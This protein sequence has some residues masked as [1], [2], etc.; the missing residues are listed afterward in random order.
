[1]REMV[2]RI[3]PVVKTLG[4][5]A[6]MALVMISVVIVVRG[7]TSSSEYTAM[8]T[9]QESGKANADEIVEIDRGEPD[10]TY[11]V[12]KTYSTVKKFVEDLKEVGYDCPI[13]HQ[14]NIVTNAASSGYCSANDV[15]SVYASADRRD[16]QV[17][18]M[19]ALSEG[20]DVGGHLVIGGN[21]MLNTSDS[22]YWSEVT[23][24]IEVVW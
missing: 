7:A 16:N 20:T 15:V 6:T 2:K 3:H 22:K 12:S 4:L 1:M 11:M 8:A 23:G 14:T 24:G 17:D 18:I 19:K 13:F 5:L 9:A 10:F 21:W